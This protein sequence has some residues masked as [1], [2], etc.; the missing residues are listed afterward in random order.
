MLTETEFIGSPIGAQGFPSEQ[1]MEGMYLNLL[2]TDII[3]V[4]LLTM[5]EVKIV[6]R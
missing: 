1:E 6:K 4:D 5:D 2:S 3:G